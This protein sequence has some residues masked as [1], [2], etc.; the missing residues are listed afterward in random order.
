VGRASLFGSQD[1]A[2]AKLDNTEGVIHVNINKSS[3]SKLG[4]GGLVALTSVAGTVYGC[5][6]SSPSPTPPTETP[7]SSTPD[8]TMTP[9]GMDAGS[10]AMMMTTPPADGGDAGEGGTAGVLQK[11]TQTNLFA[12]TDAGGAMHVDPNLLNSWGLAFNPSGIAWVADNHAGVLTLYK[13]NQATPVP[14]V[15][16]VPLPSDAGAVY[17]PLDGSTLA[18]P[19]GQVFNAAAAVPDAGT[20]GDF[21]G[22]LFIVAAEDGT[23]S[24]WNQSLTDT[25]KAMLRV[26]NAV[27]GAVYKGLAIIPSTP[28]IL[29]AADFHNGKI[30]AWDASYAPVTIA[31]GKWTDPSVPTGYAPFN[32]FASGTTVYV[33]YAKQDAAKMDDTAGAGNGQVSVFDQSGTLMKT[34]IGQGTPTLNSPWGMN[35]VPS[36]GFGSVPAGA[37]LV[38]NF[39]DGAIHAHDATTGKLL[40]TFANSG[41]TPL[42]INGLWGLVW[43]PNAPEAGASPD[44][45]YFTAGPNKEMNGLFGYLTA[46]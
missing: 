21:M 44:Q 30:A 5:S 9:P 29:V 23:I 41:G 37:L 16:Q 26:N 6:S 18:A 31:S 42:T 15:V 14:L 25:T 45:L 33:S 13:A 39:G 12:D 32:V 1:A 20:T 40:A 46:Q 3:F 22:D 38:G 35:I 2:F 34:L 10:D 24:G 8:A 17:P 27:A 11:V 19:T 36:G 43:G 7:D 4:V 28:P